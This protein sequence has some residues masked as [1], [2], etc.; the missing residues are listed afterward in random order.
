FIVDRVSNLD[1]LEV[2]V[3][4]EEEFFLDK[5]SQ[6]E[7]L[8]RKVQENIENSIGLGVKVTLVEPKS[9]QRSEGKSNRVIDRRKFN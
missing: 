3:E 6:L 7:A 1:T 8:R 2:Q 9:I 4:V 5:I